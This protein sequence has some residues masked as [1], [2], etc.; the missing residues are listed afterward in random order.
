V[1]FF[2]LDTEFDGVIVDTFLDFVGASLFIPVDHVRTQVVLFSGFGLDGKDAFG[3][4][5]NGLVK[6]WVELKVKPVV[7]AHV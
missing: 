3:K 4:G 1:D 5:Y 6:G 2:G 7:A